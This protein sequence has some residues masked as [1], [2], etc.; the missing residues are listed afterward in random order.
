MLGT[1]LVVP[2]LTPMLTFIFVVVST[3]VMLRTKAQSRRMVLLVLALAHVFG[4]LFFGQMPAISYATMA[5]AVTLMQTV[6]LFLIVVLT[7]TDM[8]H[9]DPS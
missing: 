2:W 6:G 1:A 8:L 4:V 9:E 3:I 5:L 7:G